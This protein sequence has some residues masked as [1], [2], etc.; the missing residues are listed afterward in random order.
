MSFSS[1][2]KEAHVA[3]LRPEVS[4]M[5]QYDNMTARE[6][7]ATRIS[8]LKPPMTKLENPIT[9]LRMLNTQQWLFF[10]VAF[11]GWTWDAFD[12]FTVSLTVSQLAATFKVTTTG[13]CS[14]SI[15]S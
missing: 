12:F 11:A 3:E 5:P 2:G 10:L 4:H 13:M 6:Y 9:L 15:H 8:S 7:L 14:L 1:N